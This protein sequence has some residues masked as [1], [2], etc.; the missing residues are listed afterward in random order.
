MVGYGADCRPEVARTNKAWKTYAP[1][2]CAGLGILLLAGC[3]A[4]SMG[5]ERGGPAD[6][7]VVAAVLLALAGASVFLLRLEGCDRDALLVM[8]LPI[9]AAFL[10][11]A[12][13]L[14]YAGTDYTNFLSRWYLFFKENGGF[15]AVAHAVG[16]YNV[17]YL[18]FMA[19]IS[20]FPAPDLYLIKLFSIVFDVVL[21]WGCLRLVRSLTRE[22]QGGIAPLIAF[23]AALLL[24]TVVLNG[25][26]W[27][28]CD[29]IYGALAVH[30][31]ALLLEGK[32]K[33]SVAL[34]G[35]AFS[36][37]LQAVFVLPLWGVLWLARKV[38]FREL[39]VFPLTYLIV[40]VPA[41]LLG[42]PLSETLMVY[43]NQM[44]EYPR[45]VLNA[46]SV[47]QFFPYD[48]S[49]AASDSSPL[50][51]ALSAAGVAAAAVLV[52][53]LLWLGFRLGDRLD[54][55]TC[56]AIAVVLAIGV[57]FLLPHMH[58][59]Y[60]F[61]ADVLTLCWA[62]SDVRRLPAAALVEASSG[63]SY[64][65]YL[66]L[67]FNWTFTLGGRYYVMVPETL[68]MLAGLIFAVMTLIGCLRG[69]TVKEET[70]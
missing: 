3:A 55:K 20:Y 54:R 11:R 8:L 7:V 56:F 52:L 10:I 26:Y 46:P 9:G 25:S 42:K 60:F 31:V 61:L 15:A 39:W 67:K 4:A 17:P 18:Y 68:I 48:M 50:L 65:L 21:A 27:G 16:D 59:R 13:C 58:E 30:A 14:D 40:I 38:K 36:F 70:V 57:P 6:R 69:R 32:N 51:S 62:C 24:P 37:K 28:Q 49:S 33:A 43:F 45:L 35:L 44:G 41:V 29:V 23:G 47:F 19:F 64:R 53:I 63:L 2:V 34:M 12:L 66:R 1:A 22:R 5:L